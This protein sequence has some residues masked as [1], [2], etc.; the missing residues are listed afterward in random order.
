[1]IKDGGFMKLVKIVGVLV[2]L[3][4]FQA[5][6][7]DEFGLGGIIG[8][9]TG[10]SGHVRLDEDHLIAGALAYNFARYPGLHLSADYLWNN[11]YEFSIKTW[12]WDVYYG[13]GGRIIS[14]QSGDDKNKTALAVRAPIGAS[15]TLRDPRMLIF[16]EIAPALNFSPN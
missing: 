12:L 2:F 4:S 11:T 10:I 6:A 3:F 1:M 5:K 15:H 14:I 7:A 16:G 13:V 8:S 9:P